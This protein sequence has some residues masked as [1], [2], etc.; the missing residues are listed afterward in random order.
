MR[1]LTDHNPGAKFFFKN[2]EFTELN[3]LLSLYSSIT[4]IIA[5]ITIKSCL[6]LRILKMTFLPE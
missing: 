5:Y 3:G 1:E 6:V 2:L 4:I